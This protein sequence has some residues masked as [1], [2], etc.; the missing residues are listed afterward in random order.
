MQIREIDVKRV[1]TNSNLPAAKDRCLSY[2]AYGERARY[3]DHT[4]LG[5]GGGENSRTVLLR[6]LEIIT[7]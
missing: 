4:C 1:M 2:S 5:A 7:I 6:F 3:G